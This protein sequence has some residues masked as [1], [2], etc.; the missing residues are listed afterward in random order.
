LLRLSKVAVPIVV[1]VGLAGAYLAL[2]ALPSPSALLT[3]S[4]GVTLLLK[5]AVAIGAVA[6]GGYHRRFVVP[7][8]ASG[9]PVATIRRTLALEVSLLVVALALAAV[10]GQTP[11]PK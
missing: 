7:R 1:V 5:T 11:P 4:Y 6:L 3:S 10:L 2:R 9:A 8:I